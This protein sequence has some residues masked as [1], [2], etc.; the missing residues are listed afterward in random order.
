LPR[1][2]PPRWL[3]PGLL[4]ALIVAAACCTSASGPCAD[5]GSGDTWCQ[6]NAIAQCQENPRCYSHPD[7]CDPRIIVTTTKYFGPVQQIFSIAVMPA[8]RD[9]G[10]GLLIYGDR[11]PSDFTNGAFDARV[12][13][14]GCY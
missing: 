3:L 1:L 8:R 7:T 2:P 10:R 11:V 12:F 5:V 4:P 14:S 6:G 13:P 9:G